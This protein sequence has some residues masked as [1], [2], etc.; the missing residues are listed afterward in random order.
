MYKAYCFAQLASYKLCEVVSRLPGTT[1][2]LRDWLNQLDVSG[3]R[4]KSLPDKETFFMTKLTDIFQN[5]GKPDYLIA[6]MDSKAQK[7]FRN[8][9]YPEY[10]SGRK[11]KPEELKIQFEIFSLNN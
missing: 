11:P 1:Q 3:L 9:L 4:P 5:F 7:L 6:A 2:R 8:E 10:K